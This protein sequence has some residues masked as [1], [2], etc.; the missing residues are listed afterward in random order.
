VKALRLLL[1]FGLAAC[2]DLETKPWIKVDGKPASSEQLEVDKTA[3][4]TEMQK[5]VEATNRAA[6][7]DR[8]VVRPDLYD[9]C[10]ARLGYSDSKN[11]RFTPPP[12]APAGPAPPAV[13]GRPAP[14]AV[15]ASPV[16]PAVQGSPVPP[17]DPDCRKPTDL[18]MWLPLCP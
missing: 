15:Q 13:A 3:C 16:P 9:S 11:A 10:M 2:A 12:S 17:A 8:N 5:S 6:G 1:C 4:R 7:L 18:R 14:P